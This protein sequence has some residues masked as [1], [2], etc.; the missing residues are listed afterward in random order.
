MPP[1]T[2]PRDKAVPCQHCGLRNGKP[3]RM[4]WNRSGVC[5]AHEAIEARLVVDD[6]GSLVAA[7]EAA[8]IPLATRRGRLTVVPS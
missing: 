4:T 1:E 3:R 2:Q 5:D 8:R 6:C 7:I